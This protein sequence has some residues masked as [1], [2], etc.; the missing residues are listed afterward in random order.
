M[1]SPDLDTS[2]FAKDLLKS[3][4]LKST[5]TRVELINQ[6]HNYG[7]AIPFA[8]I[9][10]Q[11][12][13]TDRITLYRT[14]QTL[15]KKGLIHKAFVNKAQTYYALCDH[16]CTSGEHYHDHVHFQCTVCDIVSCEDLPNQI[17]IDLP[18]FQIEKIN[19]H[20]TGVCK[21]CS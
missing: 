9:Q 4:G 2:D 17:A 18:N 16:Q 1:K 19:V 12:K 10:D 13:S 21:S 5:T 14:I 15:E 11:F 7:S 3:S 6:I 8:L 20:L